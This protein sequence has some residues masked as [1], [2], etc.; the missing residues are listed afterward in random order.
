M[1]TTKKENAVTVVE[2]PCAFQFESSL[3]TVGRFQQL[4]GE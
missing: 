2:I 3:N 4:E 1:S